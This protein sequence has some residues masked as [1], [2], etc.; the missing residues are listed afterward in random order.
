M[1]LHSDLGPKNG[2]E[3]GLGLGDHW[4]LGPG[5]NK[6]SKIKDD[7]KRIKIKLKSI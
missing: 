4:V 2:L 5:P 1:G 3:M 6:N 7:T